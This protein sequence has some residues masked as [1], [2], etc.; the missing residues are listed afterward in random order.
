MDD[1]SDFPKRN[2]SMLRRDLSMIDDSSDR[3]KSPDLE[4]SMR[5]V[6]SYAARAKQKP[7]EPTTCC[8]LPPIPSTFGRLLQRPRPPAK[9]DLRRRR[10]SREERAPPQA[11]PVLVKKS[12][13]QH[14]EKFSPERVPIQPRGRNALFK[15]AV[16]RIR[17]DDLI[18][19]TSS[20]ESRPAP[21]LSSPPLLRASSHGTVARMRRGA[22]DQFSRRAGADLFCLDLPLASLHPDELLPALSSSRRFH[23]RGGTRH[24]AQLTKVFSC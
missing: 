22:P 3:G 9:S 5:F 14:P 4:A 18:A 6:R 21:R 8:A 16:V 2:Q 19:R 13:I 23:V 10:L 24:A 7:P 20:E 11:L 17:E 1:A 12:V 15:A